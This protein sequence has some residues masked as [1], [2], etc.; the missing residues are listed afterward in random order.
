MVVLFTVG[1]SVPLEEIPGANL[2]LAVGA[3]EVLG[4][5]CLPHGGHDLTG[6]TQS[7]SG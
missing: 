5:P 7:H 3:H 4:V 2:F 1:L 6:R